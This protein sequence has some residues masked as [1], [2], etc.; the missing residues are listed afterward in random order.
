MSCSVGHRCGL[1][2]TLLW[3]WHR[4]AATA[5]IRRL[6]WEPPY[7]KGAALKRQR[8]TPP[9]KTLRTLPHFLCHEKGVLVIFTL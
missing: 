9:N 4:P 7:A 1:D 3:L 2:L 8:T 5:L 6:A